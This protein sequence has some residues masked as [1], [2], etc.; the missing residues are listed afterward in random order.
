MGLWGVSLPGQ[1]SGLGESP[2]S[3]SVTSDSLPTIPLT[4]P[5]GS[6]LNY[7]GD[8]SL[9]PN[10]T[11]SATGLPVPLASARPSG[12]SG[13]YT[14]PSTLNPDPGLLGSD[15]NG[16]AQAI[17]AGSGFTIDIPALDTLTTNLK[18][19]FSRSIG[20]YV[21]IVMGVVFFAAALYML[22]ETAQ[23]I[24]HKAIDAGGAALAA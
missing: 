4:L 9:I 3:P 7:H 12:G 22:S 5:D 17:P 1:L 2:S 21:S 10:I 6:T 20:D 8:P 19:V 14:L 23:Q 18:G 24:T 16:G 11:D 15:A 13:N